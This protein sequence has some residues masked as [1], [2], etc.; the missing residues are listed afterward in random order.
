MPLMELFFRVA[1]QASRWHVRID[2][3]SSGSKKSSGVGI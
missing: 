1:S 2:G 3:D